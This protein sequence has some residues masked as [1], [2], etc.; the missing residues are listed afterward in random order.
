MSLAFI[1]N[2]VFRERKIAGWVRGGLLV[3][4]TAFLWA[5]SRDGLEAVYAL[6]LFIPLLCVLPWRRPLSEEYG[7]RFT[8]LALVFAGYSTTTAFWAP[9]SNPGFFILQFFIL[10]TWLCGL[11]WMARHGLVNLPLIFKALLL[12][13]SLMSITNLVVFYSAHPLAERLEGWSVTRNPNHIGALYAVLTLLAYIEWLRATDFKQNGWYLLSATV[14]ILSVLASQSRAPLIGLA[15]LMP[16]AA[17]LY[18]RSRSKWLLQGAFLL[19]IFAV[20]YW[21]RAPIEELLFARGLSVRDAI[22]TDVWAQS[23]Q[24]P[25]WGLGLEKEGRITLSDG[26]VFNHAHNAWLDM[27][28][29]TGLVGVILSVIYFA[30]LMRH[31]L[32]QPELRP[33]LLWFV[34]GCIYS[35][36][37]SRGFFWQID[38]K[39]FCIWVPAGLMGAL[40]NAQ[41]HHRIDS[42]L[43]AKCESS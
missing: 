21:F 29:R 38:P 42:G 12:V 16:V 39:W 27:F 23:L 33:L 13:G 25:L 32:G 8:L 31:A 9:D 41:R 30:Y 22:W 14:L 15:L 3:F 19:A 35:L 4:I 6:A 40:I 18:C 5:P 43:A 1:N 20:A 26:M 2:S 37:D 28:Y 7:G 17:L 11:G 36:V 24:H 10:A 34:L